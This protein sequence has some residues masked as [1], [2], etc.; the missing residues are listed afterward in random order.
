MDRGA[1]VIT[2]AVIT[3]SGRLSAGASRVRMARSRLPHRESATARFCQGCGG[4]LA[5]LRCIAAPISWRREVLRRLRLRRSSSLSRRRGISTARGSPPRSRRPVPADQAL[6]QWRAR[7]D[8]Q[9]LAT[10]AI[11]LQPGRLGGRDCCSPAAVGVQ[12]GD[13]RG[14]LDAPVPRRNR[15]AP[16]CGTG[17]APGGSPRPGAIARRPG[18]AASRPR[19]SYFLGDVLFVGCRLMGGLRG[20]DGD[21]QVRGELFRDQAQQLF[22]V[23]VG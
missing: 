2:A 12:Q 11:D 21:F 1:V 15:A 8:D 17:P 13:Q 23:H 14:E 4:A 7:R 19:V 20:A 16:G 9:H 10:L 6:A 3:G 22:L 5:P 18:K